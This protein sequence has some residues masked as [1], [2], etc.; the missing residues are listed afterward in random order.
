MSFIYKCDY[1]PEMPPFNIAINSA[2]QARK[3]F[4]VPISVMGTH[5]EREADALTDVLIDVSNYGMHRFNAIRYFEQCK[6]MPRIKLIIICESDKKGAMVAYRNGV[7]GAWKSKEI[8]I[9]GAVP[10]PGFEHL[11]LHYEDL[12]PLRG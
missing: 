7:N 8:E 3:M 9:S 6:K 10:V 4:G 1:V 11:T 2:T 5:S 12:K